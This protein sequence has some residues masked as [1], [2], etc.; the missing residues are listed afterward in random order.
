MSEPVINPAAFAESSASSPSAPALSA[1]AERP[2]PAR[3]VTATPRIALVGNPN[4]GKSTMF[5]GL[6]GFRQ[7]VGNYP[8]VT[9]DLKVG[10]AVL[11]GDRRVELIDLPGTYSLSA[12]SADEAVVL[13]VLRGRIRDVGAPDAIL[14]VVDATN[15]RRN[16]FLVSQVLELERPVVVALNMTDLARAEG[17]E[18]DAAALERDLGCPVVA[19]VATRKAG[20]E[21]LRRALAEAVAGRKPCTTC[22][23]FPACVCAEL[24]GLTQSVADHGS[25]AE[26]APDGA[27]V[28][29][30]SSQRVHLLQVLL[31]PGGYHEKE[32]IQHCGRR[33]AEELAHRRARIVES[34]ETLSEVEARIRYAWIDRVLAEVTSRTALPAA[35]WSQRADAVLTHRLLGLVIF[36]AGMLLCFQAIYSWAAPLMDA[37]DGLF[38]AA[39]GALRAV[40]PPGALQSLMVDGVVAGVGAVLVFLPQIVILFLFIAVLEDCGYMARAAFLLDRWMGLV[41]LNGKAFLPLLSSFAC[42]V[43]GI[44][45][46]RTIEDRR[47][48]LVT[49]LIAPLMS[50]SARLPVYVLLISAFVPGTMIL[51][52]LI[53]LQAVTL[54]AMYLVGALTAVPVAWVLKKTLLKGPS[55]V[56]L[57][58]LPTFKWPS[59][60]TV[61]FRVYEQGREFC[62]TA[63][64]IIFAVTVVV[65]ALGYYPR[66]AAVAEAF[67]RERAALAE[68]TATD[69]GGEAAGADLEARLAEVDQREAGAYLRQSLLGRMGHW[70]EPAVRPLG[71]DWRVGMAVLAAFPAREVFVATLGT[72][73]NL[74]AEADEGSE[75]LR[76]MLRAATWP[77]GTAV[78]NLPVALSLMVFF[79]LCCQCGGTLAT[80]RRETKSWGWTG[81]TFAYMTGLAYA[82][83]WLTYEIAGRFA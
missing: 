12:T 18:V 81:F 20:F 42:A 32:L 57:M 78:F 31:D 10:E 41:G 33:L 43:P 63:G 13:D 46:A 58:E 76:E 64:T 73:Y 68:P 75:S 24:D 52:G 16:L 17:L 36:L 19:V 34:G 37:V 11:E 40:I 74:G 49:I 8:G 67:A 62:I 48:R 82:G 39:G 70:I 23:S 28:R 60:S 26:A 80:I 3:G 5:N 29:A 66:P 7:R 9:V 30:A 51:G 83:A 56:F 69:A 38:G 72:I 15:L 35:S 71:W 65:W 61:F 21:R 6:T 4:T 59:P 54:L 50:C 25:G 44:L 77:D 55:P 27:G 45:A 22:P 14:A 53:R 47:D 79:A 1:C 2:D